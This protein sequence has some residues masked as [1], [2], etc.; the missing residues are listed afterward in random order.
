MGDWE[1]VIPPMKREAVRKEVLKGEEVVPLLP[2]QHLWFLTSF[3]AFQCVLFLK[4][5]SFFSPIMKIH[6]WIKNNTAVH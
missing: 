5:L 2:D 1:R 3:W 6:T 4:S